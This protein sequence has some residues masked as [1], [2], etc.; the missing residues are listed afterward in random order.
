M[1]KPLLAAGDLARERD[2]VRVF[3]GGFHGDGEAVAWP[4]I[5]HLPPRGFDAAATAAD[6]LLELYLNDATMHVDDIDHF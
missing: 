4:G 3:I 6:I 1:S 5:T 2:L